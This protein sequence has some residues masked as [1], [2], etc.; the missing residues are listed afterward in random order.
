MERS[1]RL[2]LCG[3]GINP[4][5]TAVRIDKG[6]TGIDEGLYPANGKGSLGQVARSLAAD[7]VI[8]LLFILIHLFTGLLRS[9]L[10]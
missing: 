7:V 2:D 4:P 9:P 6:E 1:S 5:V 3:V 8:L 10:L